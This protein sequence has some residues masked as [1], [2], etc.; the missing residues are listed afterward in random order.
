MKKLIFPLIFIL[1]RTTLVAQNLHIVD[2]LQLELKKLAVQ[3]KEIADARNLLTDSAK[4]N[5]FY[6]LYLQYADNYDDSALVYAHQCLSVSQKAGYKKG[7]INGYHALGSIAARLKHFQQA[8]EYFN[9]ELDMSSET[10]DSIAT[11]QCYTD[12]ALIYQSQTNFPEAL[13]FHLKALKIR[14]KTGDNRGLGISNLDMGNIY[15]SENNLDEAL[16]Y[17]KYALIAFKKM[18]FKKGIAAA[19]NNIAVTEQRTGDYSGALINYTNS[20][21]LLEELGDL[22]GLADFNLSVSQIYVQQG[23]Y[24]LAL[25]NLN[26]ALGY[27]TKTK[28]RNAMGQAFAVLASINEKQGH[29]KA[30]L[31]YE[32]RALELAHEVGARD[33]EVDEYASLAEINAALHNYKS[34]YENEV[35]Y[36]Q[37]YD[38]IYNKEN[39][40]KLASAQLQYDFSRQEDSAKADQQKKDV[41][42]QQRIKR[43]QAFTG[44]GLAGFILVALLLFFVYRNYTNQRKANA[45]LAIAKERAEQSEKF[46]EQFLANMSH[47]IRTPMH[48]VLGMTN[49]VLDTPVSEKQNIYLQAIKKSS[50]NLL[51][52]LNDILD[53]SKLEAG[54]MELEKNPFRLRDIV[55]H[56]AEIMRFKTDEK[57]LQFHVKIAEDVP[58]VL[59]GDAA[60]LNQILLNLLGNAIK[61]TDTGSVSLSVYSEQGAVERQLNIAFIV[62]DTGIGMS[63]E[64]QQ[65]IFRS[66]VQGDIHTSRK[67][68]GTGLGLA[69]SK[70]LVELQGGTIAVHSEPGKG[71]EFKFVIPYK[72]GKE[73]E[74]LVTLQAQQNDYSSLKK[75][76]LLVVEDNEFNQI[77][78]KDT[79]ENLLPGIHIEIA[80][81]GKTACEK[82][83]R[84]DYDMVLMDVLMPDMDGFEATRYIRNQLKKKLPVVAL[85]ASVI[86]SDLDKCMAAGMTGY[87]PKPFTRDELLQELMQQ[88]HNN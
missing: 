56:A 79:L 37:L 14:E 1:A 13:N 39:E 51:V 78:I 33:D 50:E 85:T 84:N 49:L 68:G 57:D 46:K 62:S 44:F 55:N 11:A 35:F 88:I 65:K 60:R 87:I 23:N 53:L 71:S 29:L 63:A 21:Q 19:Y 26:K 7:V 58:Q 3:K 43:Q 67:Y 54:K 25:E 2:S 48:A 61:F 66:F 15:V 82:V 86:R 8:F 69:I 24:P 70:T 38:S 75:L 18:N 81:N 17:F 9:K 27:Y 31:D 64:Q 76:K 16:K 47:E 72:E 45:A 42:T 34:A 22:S 83:E 28:N 77:V 36:K 59:I 74:A 6:G 32:S 5:L 41:I 52:I 20:E 30:A 10:R 12:M 40:R 73:D 4:A 80:G